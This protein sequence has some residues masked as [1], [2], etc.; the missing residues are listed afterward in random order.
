MHGL[1]WKK[2]VRLSKEVKVIFIKLICYVTN[3][4]FVYQN[5]L[6]DLF[7]TNQKEF[8]EMRQRTNPAC[9]YDSNNQNSNPKHVDSLYEY[10]IGCRKLSA[11]SQDI[12]LSREPQKKAH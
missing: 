1:T 10:Y 8:E 9:V 12:T 6:H 2:R 5:I 7:C 4:I 11:R 3:K